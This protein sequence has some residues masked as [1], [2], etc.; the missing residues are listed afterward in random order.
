MTIDVEHI[1]IIILNNHSFLQHC[2]ERLHCYHLYLA[3]EETDPENFLIVC[4][5]FIVKEWEIIV[6]VVS[7]P[8]N[9]GFVV[10][11]PRIVP[12][13]SWEPRS[14]LNTLRSGYVWPCL[15]NTEER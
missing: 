10:E 14:C 13:A 9:G 4:V 1:F 6:R 2:E 12:C 3:A 7:H 11:S 15:C 5:I 8:A